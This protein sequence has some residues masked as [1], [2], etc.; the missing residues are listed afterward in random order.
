M[1]RQ[2][3]KTGYIFLGRGQYAVHH[4]VLFLTFSQS[5]K[6][7]FGVLVFYWASSELLFT[8][9]DEPFSL[10]PVLHYFLGPI[11]RNRCLHNSFAIESYNLLPVSTSYFASHSF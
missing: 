10:D 1:L 8:I 2:R 11:Q 3:E 6:L 5:Q 4:L 7:Q 9:H